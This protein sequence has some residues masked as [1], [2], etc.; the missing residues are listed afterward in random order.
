MKKC[1]GFLV[2]LAVLLTVPSCK[3]ADAPVS[4]ET[5]G[6]S[7]VTFGTLPEPSLE[8]T[9]AAETV[10]IEISTEEYP[11]DLP[12]P[13][14]REEFSFPQEFYGELSALI[15]K[16]G[17]NEGC[18]N[19]PEC[20]CKP[21][22]E[23]LDEEGNVIEP[24]KKTLSL[25]FYD[26]NSGFEFS[27]NPGAHY[28]VAST[29]KIPFCAYIFMQAEGGAIDLEEI[30]TYEQ[31]HYF[32]GTGEIVKG[33]FGQQF[34]VRELLRLAITVSDNVAYEMLKDLVPWADFGEFLNINGCTHETDYRQ[35]KQKICCESAGVYG[36]IMAGY[37]RGG[38]EYSAEFGNDLLNTRMPMIVSEYPTYRKYGW[39]GYS[40][41][42]IAYVDAPRPY[43]LAILTNFENEGY[44]DIPIFKEISGLV[45]KYSQEDRE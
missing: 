5:K 6:V 7:I 37:L 2:I 35:S 26:I 3:K 10:P 31:R 16:Y 15:E 14:F 9:T 19:T 29:V 21:E 43:I 24:R 25:Y 8:E 36:K 20:S 30:R 27:L 32:E 23:V 33:D 38:G 4:S 1:V 22:Y 44:V 40:F 17:L 18:D 45:E 42:D 12:N 28:P 39:A 11:D 41:H 13:V 34:S